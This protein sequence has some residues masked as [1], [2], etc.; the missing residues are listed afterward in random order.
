M[1]C[2]GR[3][4]ALEDRSI[5]LGQNDPRRQRRQFIVTDVHEREQ[6]RQAAVLVGRR[7][8]PFCFIRSVDR[9]RQHYVGNQP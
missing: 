1:G 6:F 4:G 3:E 9:S 5:F 2:A 7:E 8:V